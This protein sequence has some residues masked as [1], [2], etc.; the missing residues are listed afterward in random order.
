MHPIDFYN[1]FKNLPRFFTPSFTTPLLEQRAAN[2]PSFGIYPQF[3]SRSLQYKDLEKLHDMKVDKIEERKKFIDRYAPAC[4]C[5]IVIE[6]ASGVPMPKKEDFEWNKI[7][8][9][10]V[11][12]VLYDVNTQAFLSNT[13]ILG[14]S[15]RSEYQG[16]WLF[17]S[18]PNQQQA[19]S[20]LFR[21]DLSKEPQNNLH[22]LFELVVYT[23]QGE[24]QQQVTCAWGSIPVS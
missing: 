14:A 5:E 1:A 12:I 15:W 23:T 8:H 9:R 21:T 3:D 20:F 4:G 19:R 11:R 17:N 18:S 6:E 22:L 24:T 13:M 10:E 16:K 2:T 7:D